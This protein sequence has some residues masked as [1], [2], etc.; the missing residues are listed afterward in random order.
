MHKVGAINNWNCCS[1]NGGRKKINDA[2]AKKIQKSFYC[3]IIL[4]QLIFQYRQDLDDIIFIITNILT[5]NT[6]AN[7]NDLDGKWLLLV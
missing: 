1:K 4:I 7:F 6:F 3:H 5:I 2:D